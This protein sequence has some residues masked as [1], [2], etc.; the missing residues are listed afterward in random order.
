MK[1]LISMTVANIKHPFEDI[2]ELKAVKDGKRWMLAADGSVFFHEELELVDAYP[3]NMGIPCH[4]NPEE[5]LMLF[6]VSGEYRLYDLN[7]KLVNSAPVSEMLEE[8]FPMSEGINDYYDVWVDEAGMIDEDTWDHIVD[9][10]VRDSDD[11]I[12]SDNGE[13]EMV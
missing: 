4:P 3:G 5:E 1:K 7:M 6:H 8:L 9:M 13:W 12:R 11:Y 2:C 10:K